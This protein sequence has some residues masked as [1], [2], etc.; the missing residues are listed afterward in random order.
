[1]PPIPGISPSFSSGKA[2]FAS[3]EQRTTSVKSA[4]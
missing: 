3:S 2:N 4:S 1:V